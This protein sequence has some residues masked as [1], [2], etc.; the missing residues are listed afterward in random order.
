MQEEGRVGIV[1][2]L[3]KKPDCEDIRDLLA[4]IAPWGQGRVFP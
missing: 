4:S 3:F 2:C 1:D